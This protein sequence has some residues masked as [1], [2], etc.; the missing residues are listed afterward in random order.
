MFR[1]MI[2]ADGTVEWGLLGRFE[3]HCSLNMATFPFDTQVCNISLGS[4]TQPT[5]YINISVTGVHATNIFS[6]SNE[7]F[8]VSFRE[9]SIEYRNVNGLQ[10]AT[11]HFPVILRRR[12]LYYIVN[13]VDPVVLLSFMS[14]VP[15]AM[16][17][18]S[19][20]RVSLLITTFLA[21]SVYQLILTEHVPI[22]S[23]HIPA[24][25]K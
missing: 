4:L 7:E 22:A 16:P 10:Y 11:C 25:S 21:L 13:I 23:L 3:T 17:V 2:Y 12:Y 20:E 14:L 8:E 6:V 5:S 18:D 24:L 9:A 19:G 1:A 15:F